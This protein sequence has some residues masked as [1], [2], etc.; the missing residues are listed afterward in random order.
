MTSPGVVKKGYP[1]WSISMGWVDFRP[2]L[3]NGPPYYI[4]SRARVVGVGR[5]IGP[6]STEI[7]P[8]F[9]TKNEG[10]FRI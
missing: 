10:Y 3:E 2:P 8:L 1:K 6:F 5:E 9:G 4:L 7:R